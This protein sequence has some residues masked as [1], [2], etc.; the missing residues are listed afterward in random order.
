MRKKN[1]MIVA[2]LL[3]LLL[4]CN[5]ITAFAAESDPISG[6]MSKNNDKVTVTVSLAKGSQATNGEVQV[7][8]DSTVLELVSAAGSELWDVEDINKAYE[9]ETVSAMFASAEPVSEGGTVLTLVF[10]I[11]KDCEVYEAEVAAKLY[12]ELTSIVDSD[13]AGKE[14]V[15]FTVSVE[16]DQE[17]SANTGDGFR[18][19]LWTSLIVC[20][21]AAMLFLIK[22]AEA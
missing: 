19:A 16:N 1:G 18:A 14:A 17:S 10:D 15:T 12:S 11:K 6:N 2:L 8:Y 21:A 3:C 9:A 4:L 13:D 5:T 7:S 22:R 20:S